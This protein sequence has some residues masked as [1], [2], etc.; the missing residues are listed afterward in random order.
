MRRAE[1][2]SLQLSSLLPPSRSGLSLVSPC[3][4]HSR[5]GTFSCI[6]LQNLEHRI[7][8]C[9]ALQF[10]QVGSARS[11]PGVRN[12]GAHIGRA[13]AAD[14]VV[15]I[16]FTENWVSVDPKAD[17]NKTLA[18]IQE[19]VDGYPGIYRDVQ[20]YLRER[21]KEVLTGKSKSIVVRLFRR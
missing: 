9:I 3:F 14:E 10:R 15:G 16:D 20:T 19:A 21:I 13:I 4:Q 5:S 12:F 1:R 11:I 2:S 7:Q 17:Y 18:A 6:G 8:R